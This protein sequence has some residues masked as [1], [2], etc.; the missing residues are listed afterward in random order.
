MYAAICDGL[1]APSH[2]PVAAAWI[3]RAEYAARY[4]HLFAGPA[5]A[6]TP[7]ALP[8]SPVRQALAAC[9]AWLAHRFEDYQL[10]HM[11]LTGE[12]FVVRDGAVLLLKRAGGI[13]SGAWY[14]PGGLV[15][16]GEDPMAAA[17]RETF[18]EAGLMVEA[19]QILRVWRWRAQNDLDAFHAAF[20]AEAPAGGV[21]LSHEHS[22]YRWMEPAAYIDR[23][24][25]PEFEQAAPQFASWFPEVRR[26]VALAADWIRARGPSHGRDSS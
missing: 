22:A 16:P 12:M 1:D 13:G 20:I 14:L 3:D 24:L 2:A 19:P 17:I 21:R 7:G 11:R 25:K 4:L 5:A 23:Y 18:E 8:S 26:N 15:E 6:S 10:R 9:E